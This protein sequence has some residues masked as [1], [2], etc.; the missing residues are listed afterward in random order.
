MAR[1]SRCG[2][3]RLLAPFVILSLPRS[4]TAWIARFL[5]HGRWMCGHEQLLN[6]RGLDD[7]AAWFSQP[8]TGT[9][10]TA[11]APFWRLLPPQ[12]RIVV[13]RRPV[14]EVVQSLARVGFAVDPGV[15]LRMDRKL[16]QIEARVPNVLS[17]DFSDLS[18]QQ[19]AARLFQHCLG[20]ELPQAWWD[21]IAPINIQI[22]FGHMLR[23]YRAYEPQLQKLAK[24]A[25]HRMLA[26]LRAKTEVDGVTFQQEP[27]DTFYRDAESCFADHLVQTGQAPDDHL[28]KNLPVLR[29]L[30][31]MG[32]LQVLT[33]R[34]RNGLMHGYL[35]TVIGPSL[36]APD[37]TEAMHTIF[38]ASADVRNLGMKLQ[39]VALDGLRARGVNEVLMRAGHRGSGPRL[40][41]FYRR[42]GAEEFGQMYRLKL[43]A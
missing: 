42:L 43:E 36:D 28:R 12:A 3:F 34:S 7:V 5:T 21:A 8:Y 4:R 17:V 37:R 27:F 1:W 20:Q 29:A 24:V 33:A 31:A 16:D 2:W 32:A 40:G 26:G 38:Y 39:R 30:D 9:V 23:T 13:I 14:A 22:N 18:R 35:M 25:K 15:V 10:E 41:A 6:C 11:G 19:T